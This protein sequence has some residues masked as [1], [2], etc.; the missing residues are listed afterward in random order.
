MPL[1]YNSPAEEFN[2]FLREHVKRGLCKG[3]GAAGGD[4]WL[5]LQ[6]AGITLRDVRASYGSFNRCRIGSSLHL[7]DPVFQSNTPSDGQCGGAR[8]P[9]GG[10]ERHSAAGPDAC[11]GPE[12]GGGGG[13]RLRLKEGIARTRARV[14]CVY[15]ESE[16]SK[17]RK[18]QMRAASSRN[19]EQAAAATTE[20]TRDKETKTNGTETKQTDV[21]PSSKRSGLLASSGRFNR[22]AETGCVH[23][24]FIAVELFRLLLGSSSLHTSVLSSFASVLVGGHASQPNFTLLPCIAV[25]PP[26]AP[27]HP[28]PPFSHA[29]PSSA[30]RSSVWAVG[31]CGGGGD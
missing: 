19:K 11:G 6:Q 26:Y 2:A 13:D 31:V 28:T 8:V 23:A 25:V 27:G 21:H 3:G 14:L 4:F 5:L 17:G 15:I 24:F 20:H 12:G 9:G 7:F 22:G 30:A 10:G 29:P 16:R 18:D 1:Q